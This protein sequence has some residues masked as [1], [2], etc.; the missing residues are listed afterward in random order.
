MKLPMPKSLGGG[1]F[2]EACQF[3]WAVIVLVGCSYVVF[4]K[5]Q[6]GWWF[7]LAVAL[8][9]TR[10]RPSETEESQPRE[11]RDA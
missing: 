2:C 11:P 9:G 4:W 7:V 10:C 3:M 8:M 6:S 1:V 5:G